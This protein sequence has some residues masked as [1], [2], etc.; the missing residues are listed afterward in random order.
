MA[1]PS[2]H[3]PSA[4][5]GRQQGI[6]AALPLPGEAAAQQQGNGQKRAAQ[7]QNI[8]TQGIRPQQPLIAG[9]IQVHLPRP[10]GAVLVLRHVEGVLC[11]ELIPYGLR[12]PVKGHRVGIPPPQ[13]QKLLVQ[14]V[15]Q[16]LLRRQVGV[17][18]LA[19]RA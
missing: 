12:L 1:F 13:L 19:G 8:L 5:A 6:H 11:V 7:L 14:L 4:G 16:C 2:H 10:Q 18:F 15:K 9:L 3:D 17:L